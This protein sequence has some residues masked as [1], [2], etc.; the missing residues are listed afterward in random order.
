MIQHHSIKWRWSS[1]DRIHTILLERL[2]DSHSLFLM[3]PDLNRVSEI[4]SENS[5]LISGSSEWE[6]ISRI[7][8]RMEYFFSMLSSPYASDSLH[9]IKEKGG[10]NSRMRRSGSSQ[11]SGK[12]LY[13]SSGG[14]L[15]SRKSHWSIRQNIIS[16]W[17]HIR[18]H[19]RLI[20]DFSVLVHFPEPIVFSNLSEKVLLYG[21]LSRYFLAFFMI[22]PMI[23][24]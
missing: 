8:Q 23:G 13:L 19:S 9:R 17:V 2:W 20:R 12:V 11:K 10:N 14:T 22:F 6:L 3:D 15:L 4:F 21:N 16:S 7:G 1:S 18:V 24:V 5:S